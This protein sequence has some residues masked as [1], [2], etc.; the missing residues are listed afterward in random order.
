M[1]PTTTVFKATPNTHNSNKN[2]SALRKASVDVTTSPGVIQATVPSVGAETENIRPPPPGISAEGISPQDRDR[3]A[4]AYEHERQRA[5]QAG[6][7]TKRRARKVTRQGTTG[8]A[9]AGRRSKSWR[10]G[11]V[12]LDA[13]VYAALPRRRDI[14]RNTAKVQEVSLPPSGGGTD[15]S[16]GAQGV[17][18]NL[19]ELVV[20][21]HRRPRKR[22]V[23]DFE[24]IPPVRSVIALDDVAVLH[25]MDLDEPWEHIYA[26]DREGK[27]G[28][29]HGPS[30]ARVVG[31][32]CQ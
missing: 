15:S 20:V 12:E 26:D 6:E 21:S 9:H 14:G 22:N 3:D 25:D 2:T 18:V 19:S 27:V 23:D 1:A 28:Q 4:R 8:A 29:L 24:V 13:D 16:S 30:Y 7:W 31:A 17:G 11:K 5:K 10:D 32:G